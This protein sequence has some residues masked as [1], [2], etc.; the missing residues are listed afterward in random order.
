[1]PGSTSQSPKPLNYYFEFIFC[2]FVDYYK[3]V[4][5]GTGRAYFVSHPLNPLVVSFFLCYG[6]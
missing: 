2:D 4:C 3:F 5:S 6:V 1:M